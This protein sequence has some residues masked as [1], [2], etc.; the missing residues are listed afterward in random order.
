MPSIPVDVPLHS[1]MQTT[2]RCEWRDLRSGPWLRCLHVFSGRNAFGSVKDLLEMFLPRLVGVCSLDEPTI[3]G[4]LPLW[5][6]SDART[7]RWTL[8]ASDIMFTNR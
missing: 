7:T 8:G 6:T 2:S 3:W 1:Q 4:T 5:T